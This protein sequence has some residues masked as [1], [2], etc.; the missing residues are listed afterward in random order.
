MTKDEM[1][2][3]VDAV[4]QTLEGLGYDVQGVGS[5][6]DG[7]AEFDLVAPD[8][9]RSVVTIRVSP[10]GGGTDIYKARC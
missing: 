5:L 3:F 6:A 4:Q 1:E 2:H 9:P 10:V 7:T 8:R